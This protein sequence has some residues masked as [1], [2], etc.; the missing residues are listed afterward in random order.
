MLPG[1]T[2]LT[3]IPLS[4]YSIASD[5]VTASS[6]PLVRDASAD[7]TPFTGWPTSVVVMFTMWPPPWA[8]IR[9]TAR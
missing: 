3:R 8:S 9:R 5:L 4:A 6:P 7:G 2:A 1:A